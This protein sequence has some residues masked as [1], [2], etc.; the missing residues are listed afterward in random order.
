[1]DHNELIGQT[2]ASLWVMHWLE[3]ITEH[4]NIP[5]DA[6]CMIGWFAN[7]IM[8]GYDAGQKNERERNI[9]EKLREMMFQAGGAA[10]RPLLEDNPSY[11]FPSDRVAEAI[12]HIC[13][14]FGI[15]KEDA[16]KLT[17]LETAAALAAVTAVIDS[18][19]AI[20]QKNPLAIAKLKLEHKLREFNNGTT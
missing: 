15:P 7:A 13:E 11:I 9:V 5:T 19:P 3:T 17:K 6:G 14:S 2:D 16:E 20:Y 1:M 12:E 8:A 18:A 4:P 10:T